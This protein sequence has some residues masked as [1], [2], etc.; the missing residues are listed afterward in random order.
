MDLDVETV[1]EYVNTINKNYYSFI[2]KVVSYTDYLHQNVKRI[3]RMDVSVNLTII[4]TPK[5]VFVSLRM[6]VH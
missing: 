3:Q 1:S 6:S 2:Y 5:L 4:E